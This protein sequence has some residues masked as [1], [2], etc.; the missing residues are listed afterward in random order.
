MSVLTSR[1]ILVRHRLMIQ[2]IKTGKAPL[3]LAGVLLVMAAFWLSQPKNL[4]PALPPL[5]PEA[6]SGL[7]HPTPAQ[8]VAAIPQAQAQPVVLEFRTRLCADCKALAPVLEHVAKNYPKVKLWVYDLGADRATN[9]AVFNAFQ[10]VTV[11]VLLGI[12]PG[13]N[14]TGVLQ[15]DITEAKLRGLFDKLAL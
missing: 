15:T 2:K 8:V 3:L 9:P 4:N 13:G 11:P 1:K 5:P 14:I 6:M 7:K 12:A 10:P